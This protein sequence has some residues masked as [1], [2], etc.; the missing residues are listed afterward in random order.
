MEKRLRAIDFF[1]FAGKKPPPAARSCDK[2]F[3]I[4]PNAYTM[5]ESLTSLAY[6]F[7]IAL[8]PQNLLYCFIGVTM[9]TL[10]GVLPGIGPTATIALLLPATFKLNPISAIIMLSGICMALC[11]DVDELDFANIPGEASSCPADTAIRWLVRVGRASLS[12]SP[13]SALLSPARQHRRPPH[14]PPTLADFAVESGR[15]RLRSHGHGVKGG[16]LSCQKRDGQSFDDGGCRHRSEVR[17]S[18]SDHG[19][20]DSLSACGSR[21]RNR[22]RARSHGVIRHRRSF[23]KPRSADQGKVFAGK[24]KGLFPD[25]EDWRRSMGR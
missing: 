18:R 7:H 19:H 5:I 11:T 14:F 3:L 21:E 8:Q 1:Q 15:P 17:R 4:R 9:G 24:I 12:V 23:G 20:P 10:V 16:R 6:G 25:R 13:P 2:L 22:H